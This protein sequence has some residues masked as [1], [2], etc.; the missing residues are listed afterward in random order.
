MKA[1]RQFLFEKLILPIKLRKVSENFYWNLTDILPFSV[2]N[3]LAKRTNPTIL[4]TE[5]DML[6][7]KGWFDMT[8][9]WNKPCMGEDGPNPGDASPYIFK[10]LAPTQKMSFTIYPSQEQSKYEQK[11]VNIYFERKNLEF[12]YKKE[13]IVTTLEFFFVK[14][15]LTRTGK[16]YFFFPNGNWHCGDIELIFG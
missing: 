15:N 5:E 6:V 4:N 9:W 3:H 2:L 13:G 14:E 16:A 10:E 11:I 7:F 1:L 8:I 12:L